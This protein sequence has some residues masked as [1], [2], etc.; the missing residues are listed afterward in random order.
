MK[1]IVVEWDWPKMTRLKI[2]S[3]YTEDNEETHLRAEK[4][5]SGKILSY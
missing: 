2:G 3:E 1:M 5:I 4:G